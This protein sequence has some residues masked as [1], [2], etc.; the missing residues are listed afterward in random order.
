MSR[1]FI[2]EVQEDEHGECFVQ[3]PDELID[4]LGW[5]V[6]DELE[7]TMEDESIILRK[8]DE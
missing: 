4:E 1:R 7:Y 2:L 8:V 5:Q 6:G 3:L